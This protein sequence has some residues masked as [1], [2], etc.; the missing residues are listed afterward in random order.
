MPFQ[1]FFVCF[2]C[3]YPQEDLAA[4]L[5]YLVLHPFVLGGPV[6]R[7]GFQ[8]F[9]SQ[10]IP[11]AT[12]NQIVVKSGHRALRRLKNFPATPF[13]VDSLQRLSRWDG[14][15]RWERREGLWFCVSWLR[16]WTFFW[17][18]WLASICQL[19]SGWDLEYLKLH[20]DLRRKTDFSWRCSQL[21]STLL[22]AMWASKSKLEWS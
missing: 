8:A 9:I 6:L 10:E 15:G 14:F 5:F 1:T 3:A 12:A 11:H 4:F 18:R 22:W 19:G 21:L 20:W 17:R 2:S 16:L 13:E 7:Q